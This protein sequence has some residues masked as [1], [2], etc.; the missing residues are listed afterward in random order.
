[1]QN[2]LMQKKDSIRRL[3]NGFFNKSMKY[4]LPEL[5]VSEFKRKS[6]SEHFHK[7]HH[8]CAFP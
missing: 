6:Y 8:W 3:A 5:S 7:L 1:M 4:Y 2:C